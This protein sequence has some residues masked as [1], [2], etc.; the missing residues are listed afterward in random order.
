[1]HKCALLTSA[2]VIVVPSIAA[3]APAAADS[4][5]STP[6]VTAITA[7]L[8]AGA[9]LVTAIRGT[10]KAKSA[11]ASAASAKSAAADA[12]ARVIAALAWSERQAC[13]HSDGVVLVLTYP[14]ARTSVDL[15][16]VNGWR[17]EQYTVTQTELDRGVLLPGPHLLADV[18]VADAIVIEGL[19]PVHIA[20]LAA[21]RE[22]RDNIRSGASVALY[23][24]GQNHRY[25]LTLWGE[26]DQ[27][28]TT[29]VTTE[30]AVRASLARREATA[31]RQGVRP[32]QLATARA[33]LLA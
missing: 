25:D 29:P 13:A 24:G 27:G 23:T 3:A 19:D 5:G 21:S 22:F 6:L 8:T 33:E 28:V 31:R 20:T 18:A 15:L 2:L 10:R 17:V 14:G 32:G 12:D 4:A 9:A 30:A 16:R 7:A 11:A 1:M 26:C